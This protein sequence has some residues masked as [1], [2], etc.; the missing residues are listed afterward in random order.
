MQWRIGNE[1]YVC[2]YEGNHFE[3]GEMGRNHWVLKHWTKGNIGSDW[4]TVTSAD[5]GKEKAKELI[6]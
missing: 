2:E 5:E 1:C 4:Y 3:L 6:G